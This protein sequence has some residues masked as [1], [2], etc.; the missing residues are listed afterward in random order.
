MDG[1]V[2]HRP[3]TFMGAQDL[4]RLFSSPNYSN[5]EEV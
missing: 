5:N 2:R 3:T 1:K 4:K